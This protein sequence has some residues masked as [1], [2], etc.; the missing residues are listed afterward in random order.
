M[1]TQESDREA[2]KT[3]QTKEER[4]G[5]YRE[6]ESSPGKSKTG[7]EEEVKAELGRL[8]KF[9]ERSTLIRSL[10]SI[11]LLCSQRTQQ[12]GIQTHGLNSASTLHLF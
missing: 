12:L 9:T 5:T 8:Q 7:A 1:W 3:Y 6:R 2:D 4:D 10:D 11:P